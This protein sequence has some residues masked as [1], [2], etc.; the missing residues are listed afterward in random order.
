MK[1]TLLK[2]ALIAVTFLFS[3]TVSAQFDF[4]F[5]TDADFE[6]FTVNGPGGPSGTVAGGILSVSS[7]GANIQLRRNATDVGDPTSLTTLLLD[8]K[9]NSNADKIL[10]QVGSTTVFTQVL[11]T[12]DSAEQ[13]YRIDIAD[14]LWVGEFQVRLLFTND[15]RIL[16]FISSVKKSLYH[17]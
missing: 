10:V 7:T 8:L 13:S 5:D 11:T 1:T 3:V 4:T 2:N 14:A 16:T 17:F 6:G 12:A 9:N 15:A